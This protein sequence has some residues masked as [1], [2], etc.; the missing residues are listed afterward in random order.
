MKSR[1]L[2]PLIHWFPQKVEIKKE[3]Q[4]VYSRCPSKTSRHLSFPEVR[5]TLASVILWHHESYSKSMHCQESIHSSTFP[6][7]I[8]PSQPL[9]TPSKKSQHPTLTDLGWVEHHWYSWTG[10][11]RETQTK[12][13]PKR[14]VGSP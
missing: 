1:S 14:Q 13:H 5:D 6:L 3:I 2:A 8:C 7:P 9:P 11:P 4:S 10:H 12:L